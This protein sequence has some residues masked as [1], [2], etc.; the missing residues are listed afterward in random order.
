MSTVLPLAALLTEMPIEALPLVRVIAVSGAGAIL[1]VATSPRV[2]GCVAAVVA[3]AAP[4]ATAS[5]EAAALADDAP[6]EPADEA[7]AVAAD[8]STRSS[9]AFSVCA[10]A[11]TV[12]G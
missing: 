2:T 6:D 11:L 1:T 5:A 3:P 12:M 9:S 10:F 8:G 7:A 4:A